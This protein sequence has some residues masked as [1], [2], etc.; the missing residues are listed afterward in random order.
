[1]EIVKGMVDRYSYQKSFVPEY[2]IWEHKRNERLEDSKKGSGKKLL[3]AQYL[4][5]IFLK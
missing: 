1:M 2:S 3:Q 4:K 5:K